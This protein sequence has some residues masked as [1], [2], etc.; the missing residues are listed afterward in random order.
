MPSVQR[1]KNTVEASTGPVVVGPSV[2]KSSVPASTS[3]LAA[4]SAETVKGSSTRVVPGLLHELVL[5]SIQTFD[6]PEKVEA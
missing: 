4:T 2:P 5:Y 1:R 6:A 3:Q